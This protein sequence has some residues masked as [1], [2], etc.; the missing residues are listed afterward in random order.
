MS[1]TSNFTPDMLAELER[2]YAS[3][4]R[5]LTYDGKTIEYQTLSDMERAINTIRRVLDRRAGNRKS[6]RVHLRSNRGL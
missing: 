1:D 5:R 3:G 6:R 4:T 2:A